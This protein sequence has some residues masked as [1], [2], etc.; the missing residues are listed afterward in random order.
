MA[1]LA[2]RLPYMVLLSVLFVMVGAG[3][4]H[5]ATPDDYSRIT[6]DPSLTPAER[7][8]KFEALENP[9][10]LSPLQA[11]VLGV[12]VLLLAGALVARQRNGASATPVG[13]TAG[14]RSGSTSRSATKPVP[15]APGAPPAPG[16]SPYRAQQEAPVEQ[17]PQTQK[18]VDA[19]PPENRGVSFFSS[20]PLPLDKLADVTVVVGKRKHLVMATPQEAEQ[21]A[22]GQTPR[23][24]AFTVDGHTIPWYIWETYDPYRDYWTAMKQEWRGFSD[25]AIACT[26]AA[27]NCPSRLTGYFASEDDEDDQDDADGA[28]DESVEVDD[29][30]KA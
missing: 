3:C 9:S 7:A 1:P 19:I 11:I 21:V 22:A 20:R 10:G 27:E 5:Q 17:L 2:K 6:A 4:A 30:V 23:I 25:G 14:Q 28:P 29:A 12:G 8:E 24:R 16:Q 13:R 18:D 15:K 26:M